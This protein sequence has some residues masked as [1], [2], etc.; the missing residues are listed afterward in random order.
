M[1]QHNGTLLFT[2]VDCTGHGVPGA[3]MS[4]IGNNILTDVVGKQQITRPADIL[5]ELSKGVFETL[6]QTVEDNEVKDAM[7]LAFCAI[8]IKTNKLQFAAAYNPLFL[9][10]NGEILETKADRLAIGAYQIEEKFSYTNHELDLQKG[11][12]IYIFSDGFVDQ[13]GG[14]KGKKFM[15]KRFKKMLLGMQDMNMSDQEKYLDERLLKWRGE[16]D[17]VDDILVM[18]LRIT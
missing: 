13:F 7:D 16:Q 3:F 1:E 18:G 6:R 14:K 12:T 5:A 11:D 8:D 4:I 9:V 10:R 15:N 2:V 17:Q